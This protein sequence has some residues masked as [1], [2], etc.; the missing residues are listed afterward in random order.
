MARYKPYNLEQERRTIEGRSSEC[1]ELGLQRP[2]LRLPD[3][4][5]LRYKPHRFRTPTVMG[6]GSVQRDLS[7]IRRADL[8][9]K[10]NSSRG[11]G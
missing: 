10:N 5:K 11:K 6:S 3:N 4:P 7:A 8:T 9:L 2:T 1:S